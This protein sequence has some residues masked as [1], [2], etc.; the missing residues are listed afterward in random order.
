MGIYSE[1]THEY[2]SIFIATCEII[3]IRGEGNDGDG[4]LVRLDAPN[5]SPCRGVIK[6]PGWERFHV[7]LRIISD[8]EM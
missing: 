5:F 8:G 6:F 1:E 2:I 4:A 7:F 3:S